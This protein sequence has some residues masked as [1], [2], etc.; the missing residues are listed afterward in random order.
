MKRFLKCKSEGFEGL[1]LSIFLT[2]AGLLAPLPMQAQTV[3]CAGLY[4]RENAVH[5]WQPLIHMDPAFQGEERGLY[6]DVNTGVHWNVKYF[7]DDLRDEFELFIN[8]D[9]N[10]VDRH[11][12]PANTEFDRE[13]L[14]FD[15]G[16]L[17]IDSDLRI[18]MMKWDQRGRFH[19]TSLTH[20]K[21][22]I[23]AGTVALMDGRIRELSDQSGHY[24]PSVLQSLI[25][26]RTL[27][28]LGADLRNL[29]LS[30]IA[31]PQTLSNS[32]AMTAD[33][34]KKQLGLL[35]QNAEVTLGQIRSLIPPQR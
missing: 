3:S 32:H 7:E 35:F 23:F 16:L 30:G 21:P 15:H 22:V 13:T 9:G 34:V 2:A 24:K 31:L 5:R 29:K 1:V 33:E 4:L 26:I 25:A 10:L 14:Q 20:G 27:H 17:V 11:G 19:H 18:F 8:K 12:Y 28:E 6:F